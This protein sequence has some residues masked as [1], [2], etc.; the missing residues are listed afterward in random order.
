[1]RLLPVV[2]D[3][4]LPSEL[5]AVSAVEPRAS[6]RLMIY[7]RAADQIQLSQFQ[8]LSEFLRAGDLLV[9]NETRV[10]KARF[11]AKRESGAQLEGLFLRAERDATLVWLKGKAISGEWIQLKNGPRV[12]LIERNDKEALLKSSAQDF[13]TYLEREGCIPLP[14]Y[15]R[16]EREKRGM[17][18]E[19][20]GDE[21]RYQTLF[22]AGE[23]K[24]SAA[25]TASLHFDE[26]LL[27]NLQIRGVETARLELVVGR[28][29]F[30]PLNASMEISDQKLHFES[31]HIPAETEAKIQS[32]KKEGRRVI[33]VGTTVLRA[34]ESFV[35]Q[36]KRDF[37]TNLFI[38]PGFEFK[39]VDALITNFHWP[40]SSLLILV[41]SFLEDRAAQSRNKWKSLYELAIEERFRFFSFG[42]GMLI[43]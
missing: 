38:R 37:E 10:L 12:Q 21:R 43:L 40:Q 26:E 8:N 36:Q 23:P 14:P 7:S 24:S 4:S 34:L 18:P 17:G 29:T 6:S 2:F 16:S 9:F 31:V 1:M 15:I 27:K 20:T 33:A 13:T 28:G 3:Y 39:I 32:A 35:I 42:D 22:A 19:N 41:A 5:V 30:E 11:F 25:P